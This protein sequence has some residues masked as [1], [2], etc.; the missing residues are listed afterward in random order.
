M[1]VPNVKQLSHVIADT[2]ITTGWTRRL[3]RLPFFCATIVSEWASSFL[4]AHQHI[5]GHFSAMC[6]TIDRPTE[7]F[8]IGPSALR[9]SKIVP[10][11][12]RSR[13]LT[14][15]IASLSSTNCLQR[16][17]A[18]RHDV[19][20]HIITFYRKFSTRFTIPFFSWKCM[21]NTA[22]SGWNTIRYDTIR[23]EML[24]LRA[25]ESRHVSA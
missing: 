6:A 24:F 3:C 5:I 13:H 8:L 11:C 21:Q 22:N 25:L 12:K 14:R 18:N 4:T 10:H 7:V 20:T 17:K 23:Y 19:N 15:H 9:A 2:D 16:G 1:N